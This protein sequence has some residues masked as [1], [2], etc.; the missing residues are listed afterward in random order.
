MRSYLVKLLP[1]EKSQKKLD[2]LGGGGYND[3]VLCFSLFTMTK[4]YSNFSTDYF[5]KEQQARAQAQKHLLEEQERV[6]SFLAKDL[7]WESK[8]MKMSFSFWSFWECL[9]DALSESRLQFNKKGRMWSPNPVSF[10]FN[11]V[12]VYA[13]WNEF[14]KDGNYVL[15]ERFDKYVGQLWKKTSMTMDAQYMLRESISGKYI[16]QQQ[17]E[18][19]RAEAEKRKN[20][21]KA[22]L[23]ELPPM[24]FSEE[25]KAKRELGLKNNQDSYW[26]AIF[27]Y[28][29]NWA[30]LMQEAIEKEWKTLEEVAEKLSHDADLEWITWFMYGAAVNILSQTWKYWNEL[31]KWHNKEY[32][33]EWEGVVNPAVLT[34]NPK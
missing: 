10:E 11:G 12:R 21:I 4:K 28:A 2:K 20:A 25:W 14:I 27:S 33:Y 22:K 7:S 1:Q 32:K 13:D 8:I 26:Q 17:E 31:R 5:G 30:K 34:I 15:D 23:E 18:K 3:I 19:K 6:R 9:Q 16:K 29:E 24:Q